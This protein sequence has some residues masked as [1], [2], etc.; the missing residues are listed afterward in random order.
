L[1]LELVLY[2]ASR[3]QKKKLVRNG[4]LI[5]QQRQRREGAMRS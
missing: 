2:G 3:A 1:E 4:L 5:C